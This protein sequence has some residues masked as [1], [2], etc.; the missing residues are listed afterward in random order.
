MVINLIESILVLKKILVGLAISIACFTLF[1]CEQPLKVD[2]K[3][4][5]SDYYTSLKNKDFEAASLM[6]DDGMFRSVPRQAWVE[7]FGNVQSELGALKGIR[8]K[9]VETNTVRTGRIFIFDVAAQY[10]NG[11]SA[12]TLILFQSL[13]ATDLGVIAYEVKAKDLKAKAPH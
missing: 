10:E 7:F 11:N 12:E 3:E 9:N 2:P 1:A 5:T 4:V 6:F 13:S 8:V